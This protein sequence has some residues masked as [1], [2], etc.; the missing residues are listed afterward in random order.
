MRVCVKFASGLVTMEEAGEWWV[1][2]EGAE[3]RLRREVEREFVLCECSEEVAEEREELLSWRGRA[4]RD[5]RVAVVGVGGS[6][7]LGSSDSDSS[8]SKPSGM[9]SRFCSFMSI[10]Q[11]RTV[12][13]AEQ[14]ARSLMSGER[15]RRVR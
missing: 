10:R 15:R 8:S 11:M 6:V 3:V 12:W 9:I 14:V 7:L 1:V 5:V 2:G 4:G 13:S